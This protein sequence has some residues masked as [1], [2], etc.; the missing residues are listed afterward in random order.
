MMQMS[1]IAHGHAPEDPTKLNSMV[2][3]WAGYYRCANDVAIGKPKNISEMLQIIKSYD[4]VKGVGVGHRCACKALHGGSAC[5]QFHCCTVLALHDEY[6]VQSSCKWT[7]CGV[8]SDTSCLTDHSATLA[9][10]GDKICVEY[11]C[12]ISPASQSVLCLQL[13]AAAVLR[14][15]WHQCSG[16]CHHWDDQYPWKVRRSIDVSCGTNNHQAMMPGAHVANR[17]VHWGLWVQARLPVLW[18]WWVPSDVRCCSILDPSYAK[19]SQADASFPIQVNEDTRTVRVQAGI[20][21]RI[22]LDYLAN[23]TCARTSFLLFPAAFQLTTVQQSHCCVLGEPDVACLHEASA[24]HLSFHALHIVSCYVW[25]ACRR[26][27]DFIWKS[28]LNACRSVNAPY[29]YVLPAFAWYVDQTVGGAVSTGTHGSTMFWGSLSSQVRSL[30]SF[31]ILKSPPGGHAESGCF[32]SPRIMRKL[33]CMSPRHLESWTAR[34]WSACAAGGKSCAG[35][36]E[37]H[38]AGADAWQQP[39]PVEGRPGTATLH[40]LTIHRKCSFSPT[41]TCLK[42]HLWFQWVFDTRNRISQTWQTTKLPLILSQLCACFKMQCMQWRTQC[43]ISP[44]HAYK[45]PCTDMDIFPCAACSG[46]AG[47]RYWDW[48]QDRPTANADAHGHNPELR[49][50]C[51]LD[52]G[53]AG[54]LQDGPG[55]W[56]PDRH[57]RLS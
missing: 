9:A 4:R 18:L 34:C 1:F 45:R 51:C 26:A 21:Q 13:V 10:T 14:R 42:G 5:N 53:C 15:Q 6:S 25:H 56:L 17:S 23:Y 33:A 29:G 37:W 40:H 55:Q 49:W 2:F 36:G 39:A 35:T 16:H 8:S 11:R 48:F 22:L 50:L 3:I 12:E 57:F 30:H 20:T 27:T 31:C 38:S 19:Q 32:S 28:Y 47:H 41:R 24:A 43:P 54:S 46:P 52:I 7:Q 44:G